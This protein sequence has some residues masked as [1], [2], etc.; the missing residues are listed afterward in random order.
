MIHLR[1]LI[2]L[3]YACFFGFSWGIDTPECKKRSLRKEW[4]ALGQG[5]QKDF[6]DAIKAGVLAFGVVTL[7]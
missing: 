5:G 3:L 7:H 2:A 6:T 1:F 4:R